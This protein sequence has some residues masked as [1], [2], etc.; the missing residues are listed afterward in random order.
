LQRVAGKFYSC[1]DFFRHF[2]QDDKEITMRIVQ[3]TAACLSVLALVGSLA[4][5][6]NVRKDDTSTAAVDPMTFVKKAS[7]ISLAEVQIGNLAAKQASRSD[8]KQYAMKLA[9]DHKKAYDELKTVAT[10]DNLPVSAGVDKKHQ[11]L[12]VRLAAMQGPNFDREFL[13]DM[14]KGHKE[15]IQLFEAQANSGRDVTIKNYAQ[16][17]LPT[18]RE[19]LR[20]AEQ[21]QSTKSPNP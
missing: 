16:K 8:V 14:V 7:E 19:H 11:D 17:C 6:Q 3:R 10:K 21:L 1:R 13:Q 20:T 18:L 15:A 12:A 2:E 5:A 9:A 4:L